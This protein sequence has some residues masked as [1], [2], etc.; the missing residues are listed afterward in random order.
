MK[1]FYIISILF[2]SISFLL[3]K[4]TNQK[5]RL[6]PSIIYNICLLFCYNT[7]ISYIIY[8]L[9]L[10]GSLFVYSIINYIISILLSI[11]TIK[12]KKVQKYKIDKKELIVYLIIAC[13]VFL[14]GYYRFRGFTSISYESGD[15]GIH[16]YHAEI[17]SKELSLL[18]KKNSKD[19]V[20]GNFDRVMPISYVNGGL[21]LN[22]FTNLKSYKAFIIYDTL[23]IV[24]AA[25]LFLGTIMK[26]TE[27]KKANYLY[28]IAL[29]LIYI[30][31]FPL[32]SFLF[33]FCYLS[34]SIIVINL[35]YL[36]IINIKHN[37]N[38]NV[39]LNLI[40]LF[41]I[42]FS[43]F[44]SYYL[45][46]PSVYLS[47]GIY[48]IYL[49]KNKKINTNKLI[50][51]G[52]ITLVIPFIIGFIYFLLPTIIKNNNMSSISKS[53]SVKGYSYD[54]I[55]NIYI[56]IIFSILFIFKLTQQ[57]INRIKYLGL[58]VL[59][60]SINIILFFLLFLIGKASLYYFYKLF[61]AYWLFA[62]LALSLQ[63]ITYK[64]AIYTILII[65]ILCTSYV[66]GFPKTT[67]A[68]TLENINIYNWNARAFASDR[69]MYTK[70]ELKLVEKSLDYNDICVN[71]N[72]FLITGTTLKNVWFY[73]LTK[74]IPATTPIDN[75]PRS[76]YKLDNLKL[77]NWKRVSEHKCLI[78]FYENNKNK[79]E[80]EKYQ[81]LYSN[82][83]GAILKK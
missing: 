58:N 9:N 8:Y 42:N 28:C 65:V 62:I 41:I 15:S 31:A 82:K 57:K 1:L 12:R 81:V 74:N 38:N 80:M 60:I 32:N 30:L 4:K 53:V 68:Y 51:Y 43:I 18:D 63:L 39:I 69:I 47:L 49:W 3:L 76:I 27:N 78:Y 55:T 34:L 45:F 22:I 64:K 25:L 36:T 5:Q 20:Y 50:L 29:T 56:F 52:S 48:Y 11:I 2:L 6:L 59:I 75:S 13:I 61:Y 46:V 33:G 67:L 73:S 23:T 10:T 16:Y 54:S 26:L 40:I 7:V 19:I 37:L 21:F 77:E 72:R 83:A 66:L 24:I 71:N 79:K 35:L 70:D 14:I 17:F 44:F